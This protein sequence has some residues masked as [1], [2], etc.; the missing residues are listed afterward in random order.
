MLAVIIQTRKFLNDCSIFSMQQ[1]VLT[2]SAIVNSSYPSTVQTP[3]NKV[4]INHL[5]LELF[6]L[7]L[8]HPLYKM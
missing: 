1:A 8:A 4:V 2:H 7:I 3:V 5:A 6:F